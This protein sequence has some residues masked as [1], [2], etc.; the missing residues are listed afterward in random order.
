MVRA[1]SNAE[2]KPDARWARTRQLLLQGGREVFAERGVEATSVLDIV[3][4]A[5]VSQPSFYN[6]FESKEKLAEEIAADFFRNYRQVKEENFESFDDPAEGIAINVLHTL[7][8]VDDDPAFA[9]TI[10]KSES[11]RELVISSANDPLARMIEVGIAKGR[12]SQ[13]NSRAIA[14]AIRGGALAILRDAL[15]DSTSRLEHNEFQ[16]LVLR[17]LGISAEESVAVVE[18]A[19]ARNDLTKEQLET[20]KIKIRD[21][22]D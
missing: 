7:S 16:Q 22:G 14:L 9:A 3:R 1:E 4:A 15:N 20:Q 6:H 2:R 18:R 17:M 5:G 21:Q 11:L 19:N 12:F 10:L 13:C 8:I